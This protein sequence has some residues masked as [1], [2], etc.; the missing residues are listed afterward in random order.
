M[1]F[2]FLS[3]NLDCIIESVLYETVFCIFPTFAGRQ[4]KWQVFYLGT[5]SVE[6]MMFMWCVWVWVLDAEPN[7]C[8]YAYGKWCLKYLLT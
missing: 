3:S 4:G 1:T 6:M 7:I 8:P 2:F 5:I